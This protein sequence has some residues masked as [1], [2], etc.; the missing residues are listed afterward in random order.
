MSTN[1]AL[2]LIGFQNDY[3]APD[4]ALRNVMDN[5]DRNDRVVSRTMS[6]LRS[7]MDTS[8]TMLAAPIIFTDDYKELRQADGILAAIK[9]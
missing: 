3:F 8:I 1:H 5:C 6:L 9:D 7:L 4:G 2:I